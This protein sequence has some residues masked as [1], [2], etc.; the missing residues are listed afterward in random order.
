MTT[1]YW[2]ICCLLT[3]APAFAQQVSPIVITKPGDATKRVG[4][5]TVSGSEALNVNVVQS[6]SGGSANG[7]ILDGTGAG[8]ADVIGT[9]PIGTEQGVVVRAARSDYTTS[10]ALTT[11]TPSE[12]DF[13]TIGP[14]GAI[15]VQLSGT[16]TS[17]NIVPEASWDG[18]TY[19][20]LT[21][22]R[23]AFPNVLTASTSTAITSIAGTPTFFAQALGLTKFRLRAV[24]I[25]GGTV[26]ATFHVVQEPP[27][28]NLT[29]VAGNNS[30]IVRALN[31]DSSGN[32]QVVGMTA[33][34]GNIASANPLYVAGNASN[35]LAPIIQCDKTAN[36]NVSTATTTQ[37]IALVSSQTIYV[38]NY[39][40]QIQ[41][42][43]TTAGTG[44][45]IYGTGTACATGPVNL[46]AA[47]EGSTTAGNPTVISVGAGLGT[48]T[49]TAASNA[50]CYTSTTTTPQHVTVSYTQY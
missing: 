4:T 49:R 42:V 45:L 3:A 26:T 24:S 18:T 40:I 33:A 2:L 15:Y 38:C 19:V 31:T 25:T 21:I 44:K 12:I 37:I 43:A 13:T 22:Y 46:T 20:S 23:I 1:R 16:A 39:T 41:G 48:V 35:S 30:G 32:T 5:A 6:V 9:N 50:L 7:K 17:T 10:S 14:Y 47:Y 34:N 27:T 36:I 29:I 11:S 8:E 28:T